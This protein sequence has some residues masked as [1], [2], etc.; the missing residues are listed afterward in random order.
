[1]E[2]FENWYQKLSE[3]MRSHPDAV[4]VL[5]RFNTVFTALFYL[6]YGAVLFYCLMYRRQDVFQFIIIPGGG[7]AAVTVLRR[8]LNRRRPYEALAIDPLITKDTEGNSFPSRH[9]YSAAVISMCMWKI[10]PPAGI[11]LVVLTVLEG[12]TRV[13]GGV[14]Y[15]SDVLAGTAIGVLCGLLLH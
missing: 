14:H 10:W 8:L 11:V 12:F 3:K 1:M 5:N 15:P 2:G 7:F 13:I 4:F 9:M 6:I